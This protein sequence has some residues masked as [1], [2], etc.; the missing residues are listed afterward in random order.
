MVGKAITW[1]RGPG[2]VIFIVAVIGVG[3]VLPSDQRR[4]GQR[5]SRAPR[6]GQ[7]PARNG[8]ETQQ[9]RQPQLPAPGTGWLDQRSRDALGWVGLIAVACLIAGGFA[10]TRPTER[11][12]TVDATY[13][14]TGQ[15]RYGAAAPSGIYDAAEVATGDPIFR[16]VSDTVAVG[17]DYRFVSELPATVSGN[18]DLN[19]VLSTDNGWSRTV[20]LITDKA[21]SGTAF[22]AE[23][24]IDLAAL[25][26]ITDRVAE[27]TGVSH[28]QFLLTVV[29][30]VSVDGA[31]GGQTFS[32]VFAPEL[33]FNADPMEL[34][35]AS[36]GEEDTLAPVK[37]GIVKLPELEANT[38]P[39]LQWEVSVVLARVFAM[40]GVLLAIVGACAIAT[41]AM[42]A[43]QTGAGA[44]VPSRYNAML[45]DISDP[46]PAMAGHGQIVAVRSFDDLARLAER[47][48]QVILRHAANGI[49]RF[50]VR[51]ADITY[52]YSATPEPA[53]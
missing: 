27:Q 8:Q 14:Q 33:A 15:F 40:V 51:C 36:S 45:V 32:D 1:V 11:E 44:Q 29:P 52:Q 26:K 41:I 4:V 9:R 42:Y 23:A 10:F 37:T 39:V 17:F 6:D 43:N 35:F 2:L 49:E 48:G 19:A 25:R 21:F 53:L 12:V 7:R 46:E 5:V 3:V 20:P 16:A 18:W 38:I 50:M 31:L 34:T 28:D 47:D 30:R 22:S 13:D 24:T